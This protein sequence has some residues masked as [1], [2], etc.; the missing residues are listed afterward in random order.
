M[1]G[2]AVEKWRKHNSS[3]RAADMQLHED[4]KDEAQVWI[5]VHWLN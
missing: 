3:N 2:S 5:F 1:M 4:F